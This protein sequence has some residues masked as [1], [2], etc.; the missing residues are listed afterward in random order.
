MEAISLVSDVV[1]T[2]MGAFNAYEIRQLKQKFQTLS[3][4]H[5]TLVG[6]TESNTGQ[7]ND[8]HKSLK[9]IVELVHTMA[10]Y[11]PA[12]LMMRIDEQ[13]DIFEDR[14]T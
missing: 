6:V 9:Q 8:I 11:N 2:F 7:I 13:L 14:V 3:E 12:I 10:E 1:G 5:N 4:A